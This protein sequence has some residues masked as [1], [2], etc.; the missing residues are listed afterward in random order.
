[1][2]YQA[3]PSKKMMLVKEEERNKFHFSTSDT[4]LP[5]SCSMHMIKILS[6]LF[7]LVGFYAPLPSNLTFPLLTCI[8]LAKGIFKSGPAMAT[9]M[10]KLTGCWFAYWESKSCEPAKSQLPPAYSVQ[11]SCEYMFLFQNHPT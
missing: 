9:F 5:D 1:M 4:S 10:F 7:S 8:T 3:C 2:E 11:R 6:I